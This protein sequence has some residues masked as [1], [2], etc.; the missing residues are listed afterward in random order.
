MNNQNN[1]E[2]ILEIKNNSSLIPYDLSKYSFT[3]SLKGANKYDWLIANDTTSERLV[4][5]ARQRG[6]R[7]FWWQLAPYNFLGRN[8]FPKV[9]E[10]NLPFSSPLQI[11]ISSISSSK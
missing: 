4:K 11:I 2:N 8:I 5:K 7:I 10:F 3:L 9:G 6:M 1:S